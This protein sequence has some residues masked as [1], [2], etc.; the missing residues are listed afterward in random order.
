MRVGWRQ[1]F[2]LM[3]L[4]GAMLAG[5]AI[6][7]AEFDLGR[8]WPLTD[9]DGSEEGSSPYAPLDWLSGGYSFDQVLYFGGIDMQRYGFS[10]YV[11]TAWSPAPGRDGF[12]LRL[13]ASDGFDS[14]RTPKTTLYSHTLRAALTP[15][16]RISR[17]GFELSAYAG[18]EILGRAAL[19]FRKTTRVQSDFGMRLSANFWW[20]PRDAVMLAANLSMTTIEASFFGRLATG[21]RIFNVWT[22]PEIS[23]SSDIFS[24]QYRIGAHVTGMRSGPYEFST[25][26]GYAFDSFGRGGAYGRFGITLRN[27]DPMTIMP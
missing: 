20:E 15:G 4:A 17:S 18:V 13:F 12:L 27:S 25:A 23:A 3:C 1:A 24:Q 14:F 8:L 22:G 19:P 21:V 11:G 6:A 26:A 9:D 2:E 5:Q 16:Y 7:H 10:A